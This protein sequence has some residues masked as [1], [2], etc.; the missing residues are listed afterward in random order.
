MSLPLE[1][2]GQRSEPEEFSV[3]RRELSARRA[4][5]AMALD[6]SP[7]VEEENFSCDLFFSLCFLER[8]QNLRLTHSKKKGPPRGL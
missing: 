1:S 4:L 6:M 5:D 7:V 2:A 8:M 3:S